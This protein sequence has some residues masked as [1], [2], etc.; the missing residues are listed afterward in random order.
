MVPMKESEKLLNFVL[1]NQIIFAAIKAA[2]DK[3]TDENIEEMQRQ[4]MMLASSRYADGRNTVLAILV[5]G[6]PLWLAI[7]KNYFLC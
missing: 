7:L 4:V 3:P 2:S 1:K 5:L 6:S